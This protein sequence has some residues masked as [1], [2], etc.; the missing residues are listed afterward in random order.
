MA[1]KKSKSVSTAPENVKKNKIEETMVS[2][3]EVKSPS[4]DSERASK[5]VGTIF[6][7]LG[8]LLVAF[9]VYSFVKY[10]ENPQLDD[11]LVSPSLSTVPTTTKESV[12][13]INGNATG[14][15]TVYVYVNGEK[16]ESVK[17]GENGNFSSDISLANEGE[18]EVTVAGVKGFPTRYLS[19]QSLK[20]TIVIDRQAPVLKDIKYSSEVGTKTFT[21]IGTSEKGAQIIVKRG[22]DY[23]S[24]EC[25]D[26]GN[27]KIVSIAL[28]EGVNVFNMVIRD[29]AG[30]ETVLENQIKVT[31]SPNSSVNGDAVRDNSI[32]VAAGEFSRMTDFLLGNNLVTVFGILA[33]L[34]SLTTSSVLYLKSKRE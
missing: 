15:D 32:P 18:Y 33:L 24:A 25:D 6:I 3:V 13:T 20:E 28:D 22:T 12:V 7:I 9:G 23:Y 19:A 4:K 21:V 1:K 30:N 31:Y 34:G 5:A 26:Q 10:R 17:V 27:F 2:K 14:Y 11:S 8:I 16:V 29:A